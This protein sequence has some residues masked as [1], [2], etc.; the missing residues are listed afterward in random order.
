MK[1]MLIYLFICFLCNFLQVDELAA[2]LMDSDISTR[3]DKSTASL[4][5]RYSRAGK[6]KTD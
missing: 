6:N 1:R 4:G 3:V 2:D 5:R